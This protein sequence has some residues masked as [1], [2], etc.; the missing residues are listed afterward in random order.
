MPKTLY[1][2]P[3]GFCLPSQVVHTLNLEEHGENMEKKKK[4]S[5][6]TSFQITY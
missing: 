4:K 3:P 5:P 2:F 1:F 6:K